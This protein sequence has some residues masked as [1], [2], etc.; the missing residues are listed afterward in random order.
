M[1][2][3]P[4]GNKRSR[5]ISEE[6][7]RRAYEC[8]NAGMSAQAT[9]D[10]LTEHGNHGN[11]STRS[12]HRWWRDRWVA[13]LEHNTRK[14]SEDIADIRKK[15]WKATVMAEDN[16]SYLGERNYWWN[17][18]ISLVHILMRAALQ[19]DAGPVIGQAIIYPEVEKWY[20][21]IRELRR[22]TPPLALPEPAIKSAEEDMEEFLQEYG[23]NVRLPK[24]IL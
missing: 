6:L 16:L 22:M 9:A 5:M 21:D 18:Y 23:R 2:K 20:G 10:Y 7:K 19:K 8:A 12:V 13:S 14:A 15:A 17:L 11:V 24:E 1:T 3:R 4:R